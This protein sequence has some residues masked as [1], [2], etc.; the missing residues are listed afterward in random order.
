MPGIGR[1]CGREYNT[2]RSG[3]HGGLQLHAPPV[4][5]LGFR[6][7]SRLKLCRATVDFRKLWLT[8]VTGREIN[9]AY[10]NAGSKLR[11]TIDPAFPIALLW[12]L[13]AS[14]LCVLLGTINL[15]RTNRSQDAALAWICTLGSLC[16]LI[17]TII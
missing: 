16:W 3:A 7:P 5:K 15:L 2:A 8:I 11:R 4:A 13:C 6:P 10:Q 14:V 1:T 9:M 12:S 17:I